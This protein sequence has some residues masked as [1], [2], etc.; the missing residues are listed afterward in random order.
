M[1]RSGGYIFFS[2]VSLLFVLTLSFCSKKKNQPGAEFVGE[3]TDNTTNLTIAKNGEGSYSYYS[4]GVSKSAT[5]NVQ[6]KG[7]ELKVGIKKF[8]LNARPTEIISGSTNTK[9]TYIVLDYDTLFKT[10]YT[11]PTVDYCKDG[12]RNNDEDGVDCGGNCKPCETCTDGIMNQNEA[13]V[14]CGGVCDPCT[15]SACNTELGYTEGTYFTSKQAVGASGTISDFGVDVLLSRLTSDYLIEF[16][17]ASFFSMPMNTSRFVTIGDS[18]D[19]YYYPGRFCTVRFN[20]SGYIYYV[21]EGQKIYFSRINQN[22]YNIK[23]CLLK[24]Q[25]GSNT[26]YLSANA[27]FTLN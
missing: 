26:Y 7:D 11:K 17:D 6:V 16:E 27:N 2:V 1:K 13:G 9:N 4:G 20:L 5:G 10:P 18:F 12:I 19:K 24:V 14:D 15:T 8:K 25:Y 23:F 21:E 3:W 22:E